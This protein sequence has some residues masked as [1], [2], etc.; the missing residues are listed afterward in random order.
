MSKRKNNLDLGTLESLHKIHTHIMQGHTGGLL[1][2]SE[3]LDVPHS[4][5]HRN[6]NLLRQLGAE[7]EYDKKLCTYYYE[8]EFIFNYEVKAR[9]KKS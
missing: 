9:P 8:N 3:K 5:L 7:I 1:K 2:F 6:L 4:T